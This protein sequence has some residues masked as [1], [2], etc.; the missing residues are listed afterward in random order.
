MRRKM[1][2]IIS[3]LEADGFESHKDQ[4]LSDE[5]SKALRTLI[6]TGCV[7][8]LHAWGGD[9]IDLTLLNHSFTYQLERR[10]IWLNRF[11]GFFAG[12]AVTVVA[13]L[14]LRVVL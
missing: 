11:Y 6:D 4:I 9:I 12:V 1:N 8:P 2:Q 7:K 14:L 5:Y 13:E 10:E 3:W